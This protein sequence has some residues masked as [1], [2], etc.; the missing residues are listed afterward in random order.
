MKSILKTNMVMEYLQA[1]S[2]E[3]TGLPKN[4]NNEVVKKNTE[5]GVT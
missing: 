2:V 5:I 3:R 4:S 1:K